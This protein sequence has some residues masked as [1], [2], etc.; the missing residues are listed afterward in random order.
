MSDP[1]F[2]IST[3]LEAANA[4]RFGRGQVRVV[5]PTGA[6]YLNELVRQYPKGLV[7]QTFAA[8]V[9]AAV[10]ADSYDTI[11]VLPG[12]HTLTAT[13]TVSK[14]MLITGLD[15]FKDKTFL[16]GPD[17]ASIPAI[18]V[19][20]TCTLR[21]LSIATG[22]EDGST[23]ALKVAANAGN[24]VIEDCVFPDYGAFGNYG[25]W[26]LGGRV[27]VRRCRFTDVGNGIF[28]DLSAA[29]VN[30]LYVEDCHLSGN[31]TAIGGTASSAYSLVDLCIKR[32]VVSDWSTLA[33]D[34]ANGGAGAY[35]GLV[36]DCIFDVADQT[37]KASFV[38]LD[39]TVLYVAN[40]GLDGVS[41]AQPA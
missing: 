1:T 8:A 13:V 30:G 34:L 23:Y 7:Y 29:D 27:T 37:A 14:P 35:S 12:A 22:D 36:A 17:G 39:A 6:S 31:A 33:L 21:H 10:A 16:I 18:I 19:S 5:V 15:G 38:D 11:L 4:V 3:A 32:C 26:I 28:V 41:A 24:T 25:L 40:M 20:D 2:R 9:A